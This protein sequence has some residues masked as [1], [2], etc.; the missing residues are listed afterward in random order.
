MLR[1]RWVA[2]EALTGLCVTAAATI[3]CA[4]SLLGLEAVFY[5]SPAA[6]LILEAAA[7]LL[8][9][10]VFAFQVIR[11]IVAPLSPESLARIVER[12]FG[13]LNQQ[14]VTALQLSNAS[15]SAGISQE[16]ADAAIAQANQVASGLDLRALPDRRPL[17]QWGM[18]CGTLLVLAASPFMV[19]SSLLNAAAGRLAHPFETYIRP[20]DTIVSLKPGNADIIAGEPFEIIADLEGVVPL[21]T[22]L[23]TREQPVREEATRWQALS[24]PVRRNRVHHRFDSVTRSFEY[25]LIANDARTEAFEVTVR[26][27]PMV[28]LLSHRV[29]HPPYTGLPDEV[30]QGGDI[31]ALVGSTLR[32]ALSSSLALDEAWLDVTRPDRKK[33]TVPLLIQKP[34]SLRNAGAELAIVSDARYTVRLVDVHQVA[35]A[36]PVTYRIVAL[37]DRSPDIRLLQPGPDSELGESMAALLTVE[38]HDDYG[39][40]LLELVYRVNDRPEENLIAIPLNTSEEGLHPRDLILNYRW[41]LSGLRLFPGD[42]VVYWLRISDTNT[43]TGPGIGQTSPSTIRFPSFMEMRER[44]MQAEERGLQ[45]LEAAR[46]AGRQ[47]QQQLEKIARQLV[48]QDKVEW[49]QQKEIETALSEQK[50]M[51][52][53]LQSALKDLEEAATRLEEGGSLEPETMARLQEMRELLSSIQTPELQQAMDRLKEALQDVDPKAVEEALEAFQKEQS[54][55]QQDLDRTIALLRRLRDQQ[56]LDALVRGLQELARQEEE[57]VERAP[58]D[59]VGMSQGQDRLRSEAER[60]SR[61]LKQTSQD[62]ESGSGLKEELQDMGR[63]LNEQRIPPRMG[64]ASENLGQNRIQEGVEQASSIAEDLRAM[65]EQLD[66]VR[67]RF[68]QQRKADVARD[69]DSLMRDLIAL[70]RRQE[71][72]A[73]RAQG[74]RKSEEA[75]DAALD[76]AQIMSGAGRTAERL[77]NVSRKTFLLSPQALA[78]MSQAL[79]QMSQTARRLQEP[80]PARTA[81]DAREAMGS[82]NTAAMLVNQARQS[83]SSAASALGF[84]EMVARLEQMADQQQQI[85]AGTEQQ[86][87]ENGPPQPGPFG[88]LSARQQAV[89]EA[90]R[91]LMEQSGGSQDRMLGDMGR[92]AGEME[93][94][95]RDLTRQQVTPETIQRQ[96][97]ILSRLLDAQ[98][99]VRERGFSKQREADSGRDIAYTGPGSLPSNLGQMENPLR[100][101]LREA[102]DQGFAQRYEGPIRSYFEQLILDAGRPSPGRPAEGDSE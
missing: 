56:N 14:L 25:R 83:L 72:A 70:S 15:T 40:D 82:L 12:T 93:D 80:G 86:M 44:A 94:V 78:V 17:R 69:L 88:K 57:I 74:I 65:A 1:R 7:A 2:V 5:L 26:P 61:E 36:D 41:D 45:Q 6:K 19:W 95:V 97:Q 64:E 37:P 24:L 53:Q 32:L 16:L 21:Q 85:N 67:E 99:S 34:D 98:K 13:G 81:G 22:H 89:Q 8:C 29:T 28:D 46:E 9:L 39:L 68:L 75:V 62:L 20:A 38:A 96:R 90:L 55:L 35:N 23:E 50:E 33:E 102:L 27:R 51:G 79:Q 100:Q 77:R 71:S 76:Q 52:E 10:G 91:R 92:I 87:G 48:R 60:F 3:G 84:D 54:E 18:A 30:G 73:R 31:V 43:L 42:Q 66:S 59:P 101:K 4:L 49:S 47:M 11:P 58:E 63:Q